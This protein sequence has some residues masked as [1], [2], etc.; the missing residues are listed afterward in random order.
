M[1]ISSGRLRCPEGEYSIIARVAPA[2]WVAAEAAG[3]TA[4]AAS[5]HMST[6]IAH[7]AKRMSNS[8]AATDIAL[9]VWATASTRYA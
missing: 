6:A 7:E 9:V 2:A 5:L 8:S 4:A 3:D 1:G